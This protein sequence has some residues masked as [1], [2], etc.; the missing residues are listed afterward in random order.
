[1]PQK[2]RILGLMQMLIR[3]HHFDRRLF[4]RIFRQ[5]E[6]RAVIPLARALSRSG[7][8]YLYLLVPLLLWLLGVPL[9][10]NFLTLLLVSFA[11]ERV[12]YRSLKNILKRPRPPNAIPGFNSRI[13]ASDKFSFPS[14]HSSGA[15]VLATTLTLI[16]GGPVLAIYLWATGVAFSRVLLGVHFPGDVLAGALMGSSIALACAALLGFS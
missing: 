3:L 5:G 14:G 9:F 1:M 12:L 13:V 2:R 4:T 6:R 15:F 8:V 10:G 11:I 7:D 16:Y